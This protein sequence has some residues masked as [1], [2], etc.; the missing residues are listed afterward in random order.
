MKDK[1]GIELYCGDLVT[2][3]KFPLL[4]IVEKFEITKAGY[5]RV[6]ILTIDNEF[7]FL[8]PEEV[9]L[10]NSAKVNQFITDVEKWNIP[11]IKKLEDKR[12]KHKDYS[13]DELAARFVKKIKNVGPYKI[14]TLEGD[15]VLYFTKTY[16]AFYNEYIYSIYGRYSEFMYKGYDMRN[17]PAIVSKLKEL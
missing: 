9:V 11:R 14:K 15:V 17:H 8:S 3:C 13:I 4:G 10:Y 1:N 16:D 6:H 12:V 5:N 2:F 7:I